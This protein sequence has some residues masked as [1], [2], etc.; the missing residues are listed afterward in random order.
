MGRPFLAATN[1]DE[2]QAELRVSNL[3]EFIESIQVK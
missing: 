1:G 3:V 2:A